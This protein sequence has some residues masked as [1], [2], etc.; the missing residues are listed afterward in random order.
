MLWVYQ[1]YMVIKSIKYF[2][3]LLLI[4]I[5]KGV[6]CLSGAEMRRDIRE[7]ERSMRDE[8]DSDCR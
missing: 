4:I 6:N 1:E 2:I 7:I 5:I 8:T 3:K